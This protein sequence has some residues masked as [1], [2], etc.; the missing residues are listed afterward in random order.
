MPYD[1][2]AETTMLLFIA[3]IIG[4]AVVPSTAL[5][6]LQGRN[7]RIAKVGAVITQHAVRT[8]ILNGE[9][10]NARSE[11]GIAAGRASRGD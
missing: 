6:A 11:N 5:T 9:R 7:D 1:R 3:V 8:G 10:V 2:V 4:A